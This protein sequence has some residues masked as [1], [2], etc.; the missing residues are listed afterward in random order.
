MNPLQQLYLQAIIKQQSQD[1]VKQEEGTS[2]QSIQYLQRQQLMQII[3][4]SQ[5][6]EPNKNISLLD[7]QNRLTQYFQHQLAK[8]QS[9]M[10]TDVVDFQIPYF[11]QVLANLILHGLKQIQ[12]SDPETISLL[13]QQYVQQPLKISLSFSLFQTVSIL[14]RQQYVIGD[15]SIKQLSKFLLFRE[16]FSDL[17]FNTIYCYQISNGQT[18]SQQ[19]G[20]TQLFQ[21]VKKTQEDV[22]TTFV[23]KLLSQQKQKLTKEV[24]LTQFNNYTNLINQYFKKSNL[25]MDIVESNVKQTQQFHHD[26]I[27]QEYLIVM[28][29]FKAT[30]QDFLKRATQIFFEENDQELDLMIFSQN[31]QKLHKQTNSSI[32]FVL[33]SLLQLESQLLDHI[34]SNLQQDN[35]QFKN[36]SNYYLKMIEKLKNKCVYNGEET[37]EC[38]K[39]QCI[40][41]NRNSAKESQKK[42]REALEKIGPLQDQYEQIQKKVLYQMIIKGQIN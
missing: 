7:I 39:C 16:D 29:S 10:L 24:F 9:I 37:C 33:P 38:K 12:P 15:A 28:G 27:F 2:K 42:K 4:Q 13:I 32:L 22:W 30:T 3:Q 17:I 20:F 6:V 18:L 23:Y 31:T 8:K 19:I 41:R 26:Q 1:K 21:L 11:L 25:I 36:S 34:A 5:P 14:M 35:K 40:R